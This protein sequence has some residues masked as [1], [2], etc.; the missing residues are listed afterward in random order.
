V[1]HRG[2]RIAFD[3]LFVAGD[4]LEKAFRGAAATI[5][6]L[7]DGELSARI[8]E[9]L[10]EGYIRE[11]HVAVEVEAYRPFFI[12][13]EVTTPG[14]YPYVAGMTAET[15]EKDVD[16]YKRTPPRMEP[17]PNGPIAKLWAIYDKSKVEPDQMKRTQMVWDMIKIHISDGPFFSGTVANPPQVELIRQGLMNVPTRNDLG[18]Q[19]GY[20]NG[21]TNPWIIPSPAVYDPE[22]YFWDNPDQHK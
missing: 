15:A 19:N 12:L 5:A 3:G 10:R 20:Q 14:Q 6:G 18:P 2:F 21:F 16:P 4:T 1:S 8:A 22:T 17:D 13:G 9:K 7:S 11:P